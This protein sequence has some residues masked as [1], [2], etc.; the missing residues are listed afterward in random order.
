MGHLLQIIL[1]VV[2][3]IA[4]TSPPASAKVKMSLH[5]FICR[6]CWSKMYRHCKAGFGLTKRSVSEEETED[7]TAL[8]SDQ[9]NSGLAH[10]L[11]RRSSS[12]VRRSRKKPRRRYFRVKINCKVCT[13]LCYS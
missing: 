2:V 13:K 10:H 4:V 3:L 6:R 8:N 5:S 11:V 7:I 9:V 1:L 12:R